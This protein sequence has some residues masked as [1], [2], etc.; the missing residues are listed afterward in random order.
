MEAVKE[1]VWQENRNHVVTCVEGEAPPCST[2]CPFRLDIRDLIQR[3]QKGQIDSALRKYC[4]AVAFPGIVSAVCDAPCKESCVMREHGGAIE[5]RMIEEALLKNGTPIKPNRYN[6]PKKDA[7]IAIIGA[8]LSGLGCALRLCNRKYAV[9]VFERSGRPGGQVNDMMPEADVRA[10]I[11]K[12]FQFETPDI[13]YHTE[14]TDPE[15]LLADGFNVVYI[16]T[17]NGGRDFGLTAGLR[18]ALTPGALTGVSPMEAL[19]HGL[20]A[21][22]MIEDYLKTN[23]MRV[24]EAEEAPD[25]K[26]SDRFLRERPAV[27]PADSVSYTR[28]ELAGEAGRCA[29]CRCDACMHGCGLM[30]YYKKVPKRIADEVYISVRPGTLDGKGTFAT[31]LIASCNHCQY[32]TDAC[33]AGIDLDRYLLQSHFLMRKKEMMPWVY[34]EFWLRDLD[35]SN[36][37]ASAVQID[38]DRGNRYLFFPGC[39]LG[40]SDPRYVTQTYR[41]L[42][43]IDA[44]T[45]L[46][47]ACCGATAVWGVDDEAHKKVLAQIRDVW[48]RAKRPV[49]LLPCPTCAKMFETYLPEIETRSL[50]AYLDETDFEPRRRGNGESL[51]VFDPCAVSGRE[52]WKDS[53][54]SLA[55][56]AGYLPEDG[57]G[58]AVCCSFGGHVDIANPSYTAFLTEKRITEST[59]PYL[60]YCINCRDTFAAAGKRSLHLL[61]ILLDLNAD[62]RMPPG[63]NERNRARL[64]LKRQI[65]GNP[66]E[67]KL[68]MILK[69]LSPALQRKLDLEHLLIEDVDAVVSWCEKENAKVFDTKENCFFGHKKIGN[70]TCWVAYR[71]DGEACELLNAYAHRMSIAEESEHDE[72]RR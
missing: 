2:A 63:I 71:R 29:L 21:C 4:N 59:L 12:Q 27:K 60:T 18:R 41:A 72:Y 39:R 20:R 45:G 56:K 19:A 69:E 51:Y 3:I 68:R 67:E 28:E 54:R 61:D 44:S 22:H 26:L 43:E 32:C 10:E 35:F 31:R 17:G 58:E 5:M 50:F 25:V 46:F 53:V 38:A 36:G 30:E 40:S 1:S 13:Q 57:S 15:S 66:E 55:A 6:M 64:A 47:L 16:A 9:T 37:R 48:E 62:D 11:E 24:P 33:P 7:R 23:I 42:C 52:G 49:F 8:G 65:T 34:H 70:I 14:I